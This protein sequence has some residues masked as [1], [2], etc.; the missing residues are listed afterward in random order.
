MFL[1]PFTLTFFS[2]LVVHLL[3]AYPSFFLS[4][5]VLNGALFTA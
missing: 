2:P 5:T 4:K 3:L 1:K